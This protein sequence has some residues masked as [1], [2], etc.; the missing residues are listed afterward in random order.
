M[1]TKIA[2]AARSLKIKESTA[3]M[4]MKKHRELIKIKEKHG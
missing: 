3:K 1:G 2:S 4:I